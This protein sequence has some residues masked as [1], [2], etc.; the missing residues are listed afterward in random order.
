M[1]KWKNPYITLKLPPT[2]TEV[3]IKN[4]ERNLSRNDELHQLAK[5]AREELTQNV[6]TIFP[7]FLS[8]INDIIDVEQDLK[9]IRKNNRKAPRLSD[10]NLKS[11]Y[12]QLGIQMSMKEV[13]ITEMDDS[14]LSQHT[15]NLKVSALLDINDLK[16][17]TGSKA[18]SVPFNL[19][20]EEEEKLDIPKFI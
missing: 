2:A 13:S 5:K 1:I 11:A 18:D 7:A 6:D 15:Q 4:A 19:D 10:E 3:D 16:K 20:S 9:S 8:G 12:D 17:K 14:S